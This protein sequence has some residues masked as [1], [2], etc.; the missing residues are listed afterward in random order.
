MKSLNDITRQW[1]RLWQVCDDTHNKE[2]KERINAIL[3]RYMANIT[4]HINNS[5]DE[6][7]KRTINYSL[8][9]PREQIKVDR[10]VYMA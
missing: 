2:R 7:S 10:A 3:G 9:M 1:S 4:N 6:A 8:S 5:I